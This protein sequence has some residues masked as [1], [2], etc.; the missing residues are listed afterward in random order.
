MMFAVLGS[1]QSIRCRR[2]SGCHFLG[3]PA[4]KV[5]V[6]VLLKGTMGTFDDDENLT[7]LLHWQLAGGN[8][9]SVRSHR[10]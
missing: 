2:M 6:K 8:H 9:C 10:G 4:L 3:L 7:L 1:K 5:P